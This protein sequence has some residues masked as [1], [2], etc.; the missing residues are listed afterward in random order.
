MTGGS[1]GGQQHLARQEILFLKRKVDIIIKARFRISVQRKPRETFTAILQK[2]EIGK[3]YS[4]KYNEIPKISSTRQVC[5][6]SK[7]LHY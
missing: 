2:N 6:V 1:K 3:V 5:D 4:F 7:P